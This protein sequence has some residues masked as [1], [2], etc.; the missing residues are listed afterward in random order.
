MQVVVLQED[1]DGRRPAATRKRYRQ[2]FMDAMTRA[3]DRDFEQQLN[4]RDPRVETE[5]DVR[6]SP[7][8]P[9]ARASSLLWRRSSHATTPQ[10]GREDDDAPPATLTRS[11]GRVVRAGTQYALERAQLL[12]TKLTPIYDH[13]VPCFPPAYEPFAVL[14]SAYH[15]QVGSLLE[16]LAR[17]ADGHPNQVR[18]P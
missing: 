10:T 17:K 16:R 6:A 9:S 8:E 14:V 15:R 3:I 4:P 18:A 1:A 13:V 2:R 7:A 11:R 5:L 12:C